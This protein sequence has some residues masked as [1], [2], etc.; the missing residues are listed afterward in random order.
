MKIHVRISRASPELL[1]IV[2]FYSHEDLK[3]IESED[4]KLFE[5]YYEYV[6]K[7]SFN[8]LT[9]KFFLLRSID[10]LKRERIRSQLS[11]Q[12]ISNE[13]KT[14]SNMSLSISKNDCLF[15]YQKYPKATSENKQ[16]K[17]LINDHSIH[18]QILHLYTALDNILIQIFEIEKDIKM[19]K[20]YLYVEII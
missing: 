10:D 1:Q 5:F 16:W 12:Q 2:S 8:K 17:Y 18:N 19:R 4:I 14:W 3:K 13:N 6:L 15:D 20:Y 7:V 9:T 11:N